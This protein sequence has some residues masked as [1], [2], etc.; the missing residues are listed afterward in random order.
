MERD[1]DNGAGNPR[2]ERIVE[3]AI[4]VFLE[5]GY[6]GT[7]MD[8]V[9]AMAGVSKATVYAHFQSKEGLFAAIMGRETRRR[10]G[11]IVPVL[12]PELPVRESLQRV[13]ESFLRFVT[14]EP[15]VKTLRV[16][17]A[18]SAR[19]PELGRLFFESGPAVTWEALTAFFERAGASG[20]LDVPE[21]AKA[22]EQFMAAV[23]GQL[24]LRVVLGMKPT[25]SEAEIRDRVADAVTLICRAYEPRVSD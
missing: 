14:S 6:E 5:A 25:L 21:P 10:A 1:T 22:A 4:N 8:R 20:R 2:T 24:H 17:A 3:A 11:S 18:E 12:A 19:F 15:A 9:A 23:T 16:V 7:S 13:G